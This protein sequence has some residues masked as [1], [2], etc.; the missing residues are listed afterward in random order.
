MMQLVTGGS[1]FIGRRLCASLGSESL[2]ILSR[3]PLIDMST[4]VIDLALSNVGALSEICEDVDTVYHCAGFAHAW[5]E[6]DVAVALKHMRINFEATH[7]LVDAAGRAGVKRF[8]FLSSVKA[9]GEPGE[10]CVDESWPLPP[11]SVYGKSKRAAEEAVQE[12]GSKYGMHVVNLRLAMA[13]GPG[14]R[15][16]LER[17]IRMIRRGIFPPLPETGNRRSLVY[18]DDVV[19]AMR[20]AA[21]E[22]RAAGKTYIVADPTPYSGRQIYQA[23]REVMGMKACRWA[24]PLSVLGGGAVLGDLLGRAMRRRSPFNS[25]VLSRLLGSACYSSNKLQRDIGWCAQTSLRDG[26]RRMLVA[27]DD[28]A[29]E[30]RDTP[31]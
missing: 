7:N 20:L 14:G 3:R 13:Y 31:S 17:M 6:H 25:E 23:I 26:L 29:V 18:V 28:H 21:Q 15:G 2:R 11:L 8:I 27:G 30:S 16:N 9:M 1:G 5:N 19:S 4:T 24:V 12:A 10:Q 22:E